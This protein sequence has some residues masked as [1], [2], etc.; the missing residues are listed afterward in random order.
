MLASCLH[1]MSEEYEMVSNEP[2][3]GHDR[4]FDIE[5]ALRQACL[6]H[7]VGRLER[8]EAIYHQILAIEPENP[9][10]LHLLGVISHQ[11]YNYKDGIELITRAI[12]IDPNQSSFYNS[13]ANVLKESGQYQ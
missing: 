4:I 1:P 10:A 2:S 7:Q 13:L 3:M 9:D 5:I 11:N 8:A 12:E 6:H